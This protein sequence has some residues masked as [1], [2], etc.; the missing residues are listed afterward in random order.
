MSVAIATEITLPK[1]AVR[2]AQGVPR[3]A[4]VFAHIVKTE[5]DRLT[6]FRDVHNN[7]TCKMTLCLMP[8]ALGSS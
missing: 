5:Y 8:N 1:Y 3:I 2:N 7:L 6:Y 4:V